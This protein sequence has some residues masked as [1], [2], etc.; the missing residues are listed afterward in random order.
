LNLADVGSEWRDLGDPGVTIPQQ[1]GGYCGGPNE[2]ALNAGNIGERGVRFTNKQD[3]VSLR[4]STF[5]FPTEEAAS[6]AFARLVASYSCGSYTTDEGSIRSTLDRR[7]APPIQGVDEIAIF[8]VR[9][10]DVYPG[11]Y[12][13]VDGAEAIVRVGAQTFDYWLGENEPGPFSRAL[14]PLVDKEI[15]RQFFATMSGNE[16]QV[17]LCVAQGVAKQIAELEKYT[18]EYYTVLKKPSTTAPADAQP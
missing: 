12:E 7:A 3:A 17:S 6:G 5:I 11:T 16:L 10:V 2:A 18:R 4:I 1:S 14:C 15:A 13:L 9:A 8:G